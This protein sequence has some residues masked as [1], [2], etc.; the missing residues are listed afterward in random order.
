LKRRTKDVCQGT[1]RP[2][3]ARTPRG[4]VGEF[5]GDVRRD[6]MKRTSMGI[7]QKE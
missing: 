1:Q 3:P 2:S 4:F 6:S 7:G 5:V